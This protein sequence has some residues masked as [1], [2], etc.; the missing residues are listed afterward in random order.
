M[1]SVVDC[2]IVQQWCC[3]SLWFVEKRL[4]QIYFDR[5][6]NKQSRS[7]FDQKSFVWMTDFKSW[8]RWW[9]EFVI[10]RLCVWFWWFWKKPFLDFAFDKERKYCLLGS[11]FLLLFFTICLCRFQVMLFL[12]ECIFVLSFVQ[13]LLFVCLYLMCLLY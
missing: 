10:V 7:D 9:K 3:C 12:N 5:I 11:H 13:H 8:T 4:N 1:C 6:I 2:H